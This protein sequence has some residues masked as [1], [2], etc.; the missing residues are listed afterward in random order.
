MSSIRFEAL[1]TASSRK[2]VH[3]EELERKSLIFASNVFNDKSMQF[4]L[5]AQLFEAE[6]YFVFCSIQ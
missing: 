3:V 1:K 6:G 5:H 2:P 4:F